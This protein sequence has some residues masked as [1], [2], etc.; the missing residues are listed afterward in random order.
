M[1]SKLLKALNES[2]QAA[3]TYCDGPQLVVAGAGAGKTRVLTH[4]IAYLLSVG[5]KPWNI[6]ALTFTNKAAREMESRIKSLVGEANAAG[7]RM[8]TFH[9]VMAK[10]MRVEAP[11]IGYDSNFTIYDESDSRALLKNIIKE[12]QLDDK[13]YKPS[14]VHARISM[15]KNHGLDAMEYSNNDEIIAY[16]RAEN[17]DYI[18][19]IFTLYCQRMRLANAMDFDDLLLLS[20]QLFRDNADIRGKYAERFQYILVDEYQDTNAVQQKI[21]TLLAEIH[22]KVC[23]VGDD[24]QSIYAFRGAKIDNI[25]KFQK[26][27]EN[28]QLFKLERNYRSTK[29]I[30]AAANSLM[31]H[32]KYQIDKDVYSEN[33]DGEN[34]I[35][36]EAF[37]DK[38]EAC[39]VAKEIKLRNRRSQVAY[40]DIAI[41]YRTNAQSRLFEEELRKEQIPYQVFGGLSFYQR[42]EIKDVIAYFRVVVNPHDEEALRRI[43]NYPARGIGDT[44][45]RKVSECALE[46]SVSM[47]DVVTDPTTYKLNVSASTAKKLADFSAFISGYLER[48]QQENA[49][50]LGT[51]LVKESGISNDIF[52]GTDPEDLSRQEN[53]EQLINSLSD[54]VEE[55]NELGQTNE[56]YLTDYLQVVSL[57]TDMDTKSSNDDKVSLMTIHAA[58]GLE[59]N[60]VFVVG[61]EEDLFPSARSLSSI[62][63]LEEERRLLYVA[64]TRAEERCMIT[65][66]QKRWKF[67]QMQYQRQSRFL[68][69][70]SKEYL[71]NYDAMSF[72]ESKKISKSLDFR[73][74]VVS[75]PPPVPQRPYKPLRKIVSTPH[76]AS[77]QGPLKI[78][79]RME[80]QRFGIGIIRNLEGSG[81]NAKATVE[82]EHT[83]TKQ[84]L[85]K[86]A[87]YKIID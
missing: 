87:K 47:W 18:A 82:F 51:K 34:V 17:M 46:N 41:L 70:I 52:S 22:G 29:C 55:Q 23:A 10:I 73:K 81:E 1:E 80:H 63:Q 86:F 43:I 67:G 35:I 59:F 39:I 14:S 11:L 84:L 5:Y 21:V 79:Q 60:T 24:Y 50:E 76:S 75:S 33:A 66:S 48:L 40:K 27:F 38:E 13:I 64:I 42:K 9:S 36:A 25:L 68:R 4:K 72:G 16:D 56:V 61:L 49:F 32:N 37:S 30:V 19:G 71:T 28:C 6:L 85:L 65:W 58:K 45:I 74:A 54:F 7:L 69:D 62:S 8:G 77:Y 15:A 31:K 57:M 78:G 83:G 20:Y 26:L 3:V 44:T 12:L 2:Q 53:L